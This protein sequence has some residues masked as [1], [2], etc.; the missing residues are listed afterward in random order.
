MTKKLHIALLFGGNSSEHDVSKRSAHN[1]YDALDRNK[2]DVSVFMF[3]K[4]GFLL[5]NEDSMKIF[6]GADEDAVVAEATKGVDFSNPLANIQNLSEV[7]DI[8]VFYPVIHGNMG[9]DGTVQGLFRLLDKPWIGSGIASSAISF[10]KDLTKQMLTYHGIRNTK[11]V[12]VTPENKGELTYAK[13]SQKLG[14]M[15]FVK[16]ARQGSSVGIHRVDNEADFNAAVKDALQYDYKVLIEECIKNPREVECSVLGNRHPQA[17]KLGAVTVPADDAFYDYN[18]KFV[19]A[20][21][22][23]F[24]MPV[25][26]PADLAKEIQEMALQ[27]FKVLG[28]RGMA[29]MDFLVDENNVPYLGE[30]NTLPGFTNISLYPQLWEVSGIKYSDLIDRLIQL[31]IDEYNDNAK[32]HYDFIKLGEEHVGKKIYRE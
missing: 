29:R 32:L 23:T 8:D 10:D 28:N 2:Y 27:A 31:A 15:L 12:V 20:S 24:T 4:D 6:N 5:G 3:T 30:P 17:S 19:D 21:G 1:I 11:Y 22:V 18:N 13:C 25:D 7:H 16:P 14:Q 9:E 26:L